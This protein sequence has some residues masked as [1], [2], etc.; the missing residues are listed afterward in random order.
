MNILIVAAHTD[1]EVLGV[2][3]TI[4]RHVMEGDKVF[5]CSLCDRATNHKY[6]E[7]V[8]QQLRKYAMKAAKILGIKKSILLACMMKNCTT[9]S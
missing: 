6:E 3:G 7:D 4:A 1:D 5:V 2:G 8:I 9:N